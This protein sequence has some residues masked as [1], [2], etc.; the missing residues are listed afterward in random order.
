MTTEPLHA[1]S[2][3]QAEKFP[4]HLPRKIIFYK[5]IFYKFFYIV[6]LVN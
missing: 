5:I 6:G 1:H 4:A 3:Y 2:I